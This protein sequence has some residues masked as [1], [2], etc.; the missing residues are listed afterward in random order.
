VHELVVATAASEQVAQLGAAIV[1]SF[2]D[3]FGGYTPTELLDELDLSRDDLVADL[4]RI[5]PGAV[6]ALRESGELERILR[7]ELEPFYASA[8]VTALLG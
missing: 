8:E 2:F 7:A 5:A 1:D 6:D 4:V 3:R